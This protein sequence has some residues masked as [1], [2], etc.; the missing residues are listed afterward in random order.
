MPRTIQEKKKKP[1]LDDTCQFGAETMLP[2]KHNSYSLKNMFL[3]SVMNFHPNSAPLHVISIGKNHVSDAKKRSKNHETL[4]G[5]EY[6][7]YDMYL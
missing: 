4:T 1:Y 5:F 2:M 3:K 6:L 7:L